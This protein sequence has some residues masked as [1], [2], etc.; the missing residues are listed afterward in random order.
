MNP[1]FFFFFFPRAESFRSDELGHRP[2]SWSFSKGMT[3]IRSKSCMFLT[4]AVCLLFACIHL[5]RKLMILTS[6]VVRWVWLLICSMAAAP[7]YSPQGV[8]AQLRH[9][10]R[11]CALL[12]ELGWAWA[13]EPCW[14]AEQE[15]EAVPWG[16]LSD[17]ASHSNMQK[18]WL[19]RR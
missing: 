2:S 10:A 7:S 5:E 14:E 8:Q 16:A 6:E 15:V 19:S 17:P 1:F 3:G 18:S 12:W 9:K 13:K 4:T 11:R